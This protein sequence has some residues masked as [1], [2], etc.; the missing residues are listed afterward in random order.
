MGALLVFLLS[1][2]GL[3]QQLVSQA[4]HLIGQLIGLVLVFL[5]LTTPIVPWVAPFIHPHAKRHAVIVP[6]LMVSRPVKADLNS[7]VLRADPALHRFTYLFEGKATFKGQPCH[8]ASVLVRMTS[9]DRSAAQGT[10]TDADG[11]YSIS[12]SIDVVDKHPLDWTIEAYTPE[13][14]PVEITGRQIVQAPYEP[15]K[16]PIVVTNPVEF[17]ISLSK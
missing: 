16:G 14:D 7:M 13:F 11:S 4:R 8:N 1:L 9:E 17:D 6:V 3:S 15:E 12:M 10:V 2:S 5:G